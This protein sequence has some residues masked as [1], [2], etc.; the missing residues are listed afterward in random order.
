MTPLWFNFRSAVLLEVPQHKSVRFISGNRKE[1]KYFGYS[2]FPQDKLSKEAAHLCPCGSSGEPGCV[3]VRF[4][5]RPSTQKP[6]TLVTGAESCSGLFAFVILHLQR[7][8]SC[9]F[10]SNGGKEEK[11]SLWMVSSAISR[12]KADHNSAGLRSSYRRQRRV[13]SQRGWC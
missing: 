1:K 7:K 9:V 13:I 3:G 5:P 10:S 2:A 8:A 11:K 6:V 12:G 4:Q